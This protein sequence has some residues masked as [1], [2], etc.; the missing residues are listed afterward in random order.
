MV[1]VLFVSALIGGL[2]IC[3]GCS[4]R[5][6]IEIQPASSI[7]LGVE[8]YISG[9]VNIPGIY[10]LEEGDTLESLI[11]AAGG[12]AANASTEDIELH[13]PYAGQAEASQLVNI[14]HAEAWLLE[15]LPGIGSTLAEAIITYREQNGYFQ[16]SSEITSVSGIG[17]AIYEQIKELITVSG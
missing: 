4:P 2:F 11:Q 14:N 10:P 7:G 8:V 17:Q 3:G 5:Q 9:G 15:A 12:L 1:A 16:H 13:I 6:E